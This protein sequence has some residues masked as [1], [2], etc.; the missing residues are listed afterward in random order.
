MT[1][2]TTPSSASPDGIRRLYDLMRRVNSPHELSEVLHEVVNGVVEGLGYGVAAISVLE[3]ETLVMTA[4][5]GPEE[6]REAILGY[7]T[8]MA[9]VFDEYAHADEWGILRYVPH[10]RLDPETTTYAWRPD[11]DPV[12]DPE[13]WHPMD[14]LYAPLLSASG[15]VLGNM[16][17][18]LPP[19]GRVPSAPQ[20]ELLEMFVVQ[21]G[22]A[23]ATAQQRE[24][25][26]DRLRLG[27]GAPPGASG[28]PSP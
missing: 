8:P 24:E 14:T 16:S 12:D 2:P 11:F 9:E 18:D 28:T 10:H 27:G 6:V 5:A 4:V 19:D 26:A 1:V 3:G 7:R 20:R 17:V 25:L 21:A 22:L 15:R 13:A 23:I